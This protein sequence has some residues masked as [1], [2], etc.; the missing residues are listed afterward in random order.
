MIVRLTLFD[1]FAN[2]F[3]F[4]FLVF[5]LGPEIRGRMGGPSVFVFSSSTSSMLVSPGSFVFVFSSSMLVSPGSMF[6][7]IR[8]IKQK[9]YRKHIGTYREI[10]LMS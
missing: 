10:I 2:F 3:G 5:L 7:A 1:F 6:H 4:S 9:I 8:T